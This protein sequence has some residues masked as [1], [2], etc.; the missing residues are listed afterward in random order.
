ELLFND[1]EQELVDGALQDVLVQ[2]TD[3]NGNLLFQ[4]DANGDLILD[5]DGNPIPVLVTINVTPSLNTA[6]ALLS[7]RFFSLFDAAGSHAG[8]LTPAVLKLIA[9]WIDVGGQYYNDPF[10]VPP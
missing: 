9:E 10:A 8:R 3:A 7:P 6:G 4:T 2:A 1:Q 5:I